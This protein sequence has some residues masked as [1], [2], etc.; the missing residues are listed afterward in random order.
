[1]AF[2]R[3]IES[4]FH[5]LY[6]KYEPYLDGYLKDSIQYLGYRLKV[7]VLVV[8]SALQRKNIALNRDIFSGIVYYGIISNHL[9]FPHQIAN[10]LSSP[11]TYTAYVE[12]MSKLGLKPIQISL[13]D[14]IWIF[15]QPLNKLNVLVPEFR[16]FLLNFQPSNNSREESLTIFAGLLYLYLKQNKG[17]IS[18]KKISLMCSVPI[19]SL[20]RFLNNYNQA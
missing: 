16:R 5:T 17:K 2:L 7:R 12:I 6:S 10:Q 9:L 1:M 15:D 3:V 14:L 4:K 8:S 13:V 20:T 19:S 11:Q 18:Q